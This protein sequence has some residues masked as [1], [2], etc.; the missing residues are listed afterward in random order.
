M[1]DKKKFD[2]EII[3]RLITPPPAGAYRWA[4]S[5]KFYGGRKPNHNFTEMYG[6]TEQEAA[7]KMKEQVERMI[8][9]RSAAGRS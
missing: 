5:V 3:T 7:D 6:K 9:G 2:Y 8:K 4:A 1:A